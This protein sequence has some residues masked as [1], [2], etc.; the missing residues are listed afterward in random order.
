VKVEDDVASVDSVDGD[1]GGRDTTQRGCGHGHLGRQRL[2]R[3]QLSEV[4]A[5]LVDGAADGKC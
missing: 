3:D 4:E 1:L 2:R 5:L